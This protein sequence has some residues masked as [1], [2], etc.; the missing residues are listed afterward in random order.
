GLF[1]ASQEVTPAMWRD[2]VDR[3]DV[4]QNYPGLLALAYAQRIPAAELDEHAAR[5]RDRLGRYAV[6]PAGQRSEYV[7]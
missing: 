2:F 3:L 4:A 5:M 6:R 1:A 7:L